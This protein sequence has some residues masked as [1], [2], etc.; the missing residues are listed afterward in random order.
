LKSKTAKSTEKSVTVRQLA[1]QRHCSQAAIR[2]L[3]L[4]GVFPT[5]WKDEHGV[6]RIPVVE[7]QSYYA[8][9]DSWRRRHKGAHSSQSE[10]S[11]VAMAE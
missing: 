1:E 4:S 3:L 8:L 11:V 10:A 2:Q 6:W 9:L 5:A 7:L